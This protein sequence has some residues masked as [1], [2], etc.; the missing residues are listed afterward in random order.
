MMA[1]KEVDLDDYDIGIIGLG[2]A[3]SNLARLLLSHLKVIA[4]DKKDSQ[5]NCFDAGFHKPCG[6]LLSKGAQKCFANQ[7]LTLPKEIL[8]SPQPFAINTIDLPSK[9]GFISQSTMSAW[10]DIVWICG[11]NP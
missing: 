9:V 11:L 6:G 7:S 1:S 2:I 3:G 5:G 4:I 8:S 10:S